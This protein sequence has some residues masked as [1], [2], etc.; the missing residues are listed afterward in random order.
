M[1]WYL[2]AHILYKIYVSSNRDRIEKSYLKTL[3]LKDLWMLHKTTIY[4]NEA[5]IEN[6]LDVL[7]RFGLIKKEGDYINLKVAELEKFEGMLMRD[8]M[9][10]DDNTYYLAYLRKRI[11]EGLNNIMKREQHI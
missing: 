1:T 8:P 7:E 6:D 2:L 5:Q 4:E 11:D 3:L 10:T 9:L